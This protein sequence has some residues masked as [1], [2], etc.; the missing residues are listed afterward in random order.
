M[1][2]LSL[3]KVFVLLSLISCKV[4]SQTNPKIYYP[5][6]LNPSKFQEDRSH[7]IPLNINGSNYRIL[8]INNFV[9][10][11]IISI[12]SNEGGNDKTT[13]T[14][15]PLLKDYEG[16]NIVDVI[17][18]IKLNEPLSD[19]YNNS[20]RYF[21]V[22]VQ[23]LK[24]GSHP[25]N[26]SIKTDKQSYNFSLT[27]L[28]NN[29]IYKKSLNINT[30]AYFDYNFMLKGARISM[31]ENLVAHDLNV[32][33]IP[34]YTLP[35][36][37][38]KSTPIKLTNYINGTEAKFDYYIIYFGGFQDKS[39]N[40]LSESWTK[41]Y[42]FWIKNIVETL[43]SKGISDDKILL[44]PY[45]E[46]K[47][48]NINKLNQVIAMSKANGITD[49]F[50]STAANSSAASGIKSLGVTQLH[51]GGAVVDLSND[52]FKTVDK[53]DL[54]W[55]YETRFER[56]REQS[57]LSYLTLG[58]KASLYGATGIGLWDYCDVA[59]AYS[60]DQQGEIIGGTASW[61]IVPATP[62]SDYSL[63]YRKGDQIYASIRE[64]AL[65]YANEDFFWL[66]L[67]QNKFSKTGKIQQVNSLINKQQAIAEWENTKIK[68]I[69]K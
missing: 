45:D 52:S 33:V 19:S 13:I 5:W 41:N 51:S 49:R 24:S 69:S 40:F 59:K 64:E 38:D 36:V 2:R 20:T 30:W 32:L 44:Y 43:K 48:D 26:I 3:L 56:S 55:I 57:P 27:V 46:P 65:K 16:N 22:K 1:K 42:P 10:T 53:N 66:S 47:G 14:E 61:K 6:E 15:L 34:P 4:N 12:T 8:E 28:V 37:S 67:Y 54:K 68:L 25:L 62:G 23:G 18:P 35:G 11:K 17:V 39:D 50:F 58:W 60:A 29:S 7:I 9:G 31:L 63:V 21:L